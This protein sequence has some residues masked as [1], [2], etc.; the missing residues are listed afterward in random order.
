VRHVPSVAEK[1]QK[2]RKPWI[3]AFVS[4]R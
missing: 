3:G 2:A 4:L 1:Q